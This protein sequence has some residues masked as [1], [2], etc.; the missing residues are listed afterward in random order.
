MTDKYRIKC[1]HYY[2]VTHGGDCCSY[3]SAICPNKGLP[4]E[5]KIELYDSFHLN[6]LEINNVI[7]V[8]LMD[9]ID[10]NDLAWAISNLQSD[11]VY[12]K[13]IAKYLMDNN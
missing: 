12:K 4:C 5:I 1:E 2:Y 7:A 11:N 6:F 13:I 8:E 9:V 3:K 10:N